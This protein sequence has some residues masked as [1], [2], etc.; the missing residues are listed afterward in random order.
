M[1]K[2]ILY[3]LMVAMFLWG[4]VWPYVKGYAVCMSGS[5]R[6]EKNSHNVSKAQG[7][8]SSEIKTK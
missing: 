1:R 2:K 5:C 8:P 7:N 4:F 6:L 3:L